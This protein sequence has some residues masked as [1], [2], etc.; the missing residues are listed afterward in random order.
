VGNKKG[1]EGKLLKE[2]EDAEKSDEKN[3]E[4]RTMIENLIN[5]LERMKKK[6]EDTLNDLENILATG[7]EEDGTPL[8]E[9]RRKFIENSIRTI[10]ELF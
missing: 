4:T 2:K 10:K 9:E 7:E 3:R 5:D 8:T 1:G 6:S